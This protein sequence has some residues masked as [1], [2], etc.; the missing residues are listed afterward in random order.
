[1]TNRRRENPPSGNR[2]TCIIAAL[3]LLALFAAFMSVWLQWHQDN[4]DHRLIQAIKLRQND[5]AISMLNQ[6]ASANTQD[7]PYKS[8]TA[9]TVLAD[10]WARLHGRRPSKDQHPSALMLAC[11]VCRD[12]HYPREAPPADLPL[13]RA[14]LSH[15]ADPNT[16]DLELDFTALET[17]IIAGDP[18]I[19]KLLLEH[20]AWSN[21][22][23]TGSLE[24][25]PK[26]RPIPAI[27]KGIV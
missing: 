6:G 15:K 3:P 24:A 5:L 10:L 8:M 13:V 25:R 9:R 19:V 12:T 7:T 14:L 1:M 4:L 2:T 26:S 16:S 23:M 11:T 22:T 18:R 17:Q 21:R 20:G 27:S